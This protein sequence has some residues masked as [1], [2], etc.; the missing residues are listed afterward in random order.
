MGRIELTLARIP[1]YER[2]NLSWDRVQ[3]GTVYDPV[4]VMLEKSTFPD[5]KSASEIHIIVDWGPLP[6]SEALP[7]AE[8]G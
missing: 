5:G 3:Y 7:E 1:F 8:P 6:S 4:V 2:M